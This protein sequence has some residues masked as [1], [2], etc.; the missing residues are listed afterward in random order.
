MDR[1]SKKH[2]FHCV[3]LISI[4]IKFQKIR[5][6]KSKIRNLYTMNTFD[7]SANDWDKDTIHTE[8]AIAIAKKIT[9]LIE[10]KPGMKA[11]EFGAGTGLLSF[12]LKDSFASVTLID[13]SKEM[14][15]VCNDKILESKATNMKAIQIDLESE[16][17]KQKFDII[18]S[19]MVFHHIA[20]VSRMIQRFSTMLESGGTV[21]IAD[22]YAEDG[23]FHG[24]GFTGHNG[25]DPEWMSTV[26]L[27]AGF[28]GISYSTC[29]V[30]KKT[31]AEGIEREYPV[32]LIIARKP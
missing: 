7:L 1:L 30:Q 18:Y 31:D 19:Q 12:R 22:L 23:S 32:F 9:E 3:K 14:I 15:R 2:E 8:R 26:M 24:E 20:D 6:S 16:E 10:F 4:L 21:A 29:F 27:N 13:S 25:F 5:N 28:T 17:L 11:M